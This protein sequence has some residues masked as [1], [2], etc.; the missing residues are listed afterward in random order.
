MNEKYTGCTNLSDLG[1]VSRVLSN[2]KLKVMKRIVHTLWSLMLVLTVFPSDAWSQARCGVDVTV[3]E[4]NGI[5]ILTAEPKGQAPFQFEWT[6]GETGQEIKV[7]QSGLYC[8]IMVDDA[9]CKTR[10]CATIRGPKKCE[11]DILVQRNRQDSSITLVAKG[12]HT[13]GALK[14]EWSTGETTES[15]KVDPNVVGKY[16]VTITDEDGCMAEDCFEIKGSSGRCAVRISVD[17]DLQGNFV[18]T[19]FPVGRAPFSFEWSNGDTTRRIS[20]TDEG[21]YC[22]VIK[23]ATGC[24]S[25]ACVEVGK[26]GPDCS[27]KITPS[28]KD[29]NGV[30]TLTAHAR[31][32]D[33]IKYEWSTGETT[34]MI[35][36]DTAGTYCVTITDGDGCTSRDCF[37]IRGNSGN[38]C[39][40]FVKARR[41]S[42]GI[43]LSAHMRGTAPFT[44]EWNTGDSS[45]SISADSSGTYCVTV[46]DAVGCSDEACYR[47]RRHIQKR[48]DS[49]YVRIQQIRDRRSGDV[50]LVARAAGEGAIKYEWNN[51]ETTQKINVDSSG[52]YCVTV[53]DEKGCTAE[54][55]VDVRMAGSGT[56]NKFNIGPVPVV[57][58]LK[59]S[60][61]AQGVY[62]LEYS[63]VHLSNGNKLLNGKWEVNGDGDEQIDV[64]SLRAGV[65]AIHINWG[66]GRTQSTIFKR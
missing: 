2:N 63:I 16:C 65:Y 29:S 50:I 37:T 31:G 28:R 34:S 7:D 56:P 14:Y 64:S 51:G 41:D 30:I 47:I 11:V 54:T 22:V 12:K 46:T 32:A 58:F 38:K 66:T 57:D 17:R 36:V 43:Q 6:T 13:N 3:K 24:E 35:S 19:A 23:D 42:T 55:C 52:T 45:Q 59:V 44:Y 27:V 49:C 39:K 60:W 20:V 21:E 15:I 26:R 61:Q 10:S 8:V 25:K 4:D 1:H 5:Y 53:T 48:T 40:A 62:T 33:S 9:G 18:L